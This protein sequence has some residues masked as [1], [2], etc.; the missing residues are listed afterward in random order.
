VVEFVVGLGVVG[1]HPTVVEKDP[2]QQNK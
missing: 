2:Q 1:S